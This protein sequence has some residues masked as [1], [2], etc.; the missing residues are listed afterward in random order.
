MFYK[1]TKYHFNCQGTCR[2]KTSNQF[3]PFTMTMLQVR[4]FNHY[5][6]LRIYRFLVLVSKPHVK[7]D[8]LVQIDRLAKLSVFF[9]I[10][11]T[12]VENFFDF[13]HF[14]LAIVLKNH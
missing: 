2:S 13:L 14:F 6:R 9:L 4:N 12:F 1:F 3:I 11:Y 5:N 7:K 8:R 10:K